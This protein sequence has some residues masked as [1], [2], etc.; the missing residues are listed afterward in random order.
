MVIEGMIVSPGDEA[1]VKSSK[2]AKRDA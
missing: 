2:F 1:M